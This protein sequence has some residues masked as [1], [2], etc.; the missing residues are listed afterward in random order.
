MA[1]TYIG[2]FNN[3]QI[4]YTNNS[5]LSQKVIIRIADLYDPSEDIV[6]ISLADNPVL[7]RLV[8]NSEDKFTPIR[9]KS[10]EI[11]LHTTPNINLLTFGTGGDNQFSVEVSIDNVENY[12]FKGW[13]SVSDIRQDF[14]PDPNVLVLTATDGLGF[15]KD[16]PLT[17]VNGN[18]FVG[19]HK[20]SEYIAACLAKTGTFDVPNFWV[21]EMNIKESTQVTNY[22]GH[23]YNTMYLD[24]KT[25]EKGIGEFEDCFTVLEKILGESCELSWNK[26]GWLIKNIDEFINVPSKRVQFDSTG[27]V[28]YEY[29]PFTFEKNIGSDMSQYSLGFMNDDAQVS[30]QRPYKTVIHEYRFEP[31]EEIP[32]NVNFERGDFLGT[33]PDETIDGV[34]YTAKKYRL[35]CWDLLKGSPPTFNTVPTGDLYIKKLFDEFEQES[36][37]YAVVKWPTSPPEALVVRSNGIEVEFGDSFDF[38]WDFAIEQNLSIGTGNLIVASILLEGN[39]GTYWFLDD[40]SGVAS[41]TLTFPADPNTTMKWAQSN[42][43][44]TV[45]YKL[46]T[47]NVDT[48]TIDNNQSRTVSVGK[49]DKIPVDGK[50][51]IIFHWGNNV[52]FASSTLHLS[53]LNFS[54]KPL[55]NGTY[56]QY[57]GT[58]NQV[59]QGGLSKAIRDQQ[60]YISDVSKPLFKGCLRKRVGDYLI[61]GGA[62]SPIQFFDGNSFQINGYYAWLFP[63]GLPLLIS[64][65]G[66]NNTNDVYVLSAEYALIPN[67]TVVTLSKDTVAETDNTYAIST[68]QFG[69]TE[70]FYNSLL[71]PSGPPS[72]AEVKPF[73][74]MRVQ[75]VFNQYNRVFTAFEGAIDGL[76]TNGDVPDL[77]HSY[78]IKDSHPATDYKTFKLLHMEQNLDLCEW[79]FYL[80]EV[81]D[82]TIPKVY[83]GHTFKYIQND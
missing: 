59:D 7:I 27:A 26:T 72:A 22:E 8:D 21:A 80:I 82:S 52:S 6:D 40:P 78:Y 23:F 57:S 43:N 4:D 74:Q 63:P 42:A 69:L 14:Q 34:T 81:Y 68:I 49:V 12:V 1:K 76:D 9:S 41:N 45:N 61:M 50:L 67:K 33:L 60:V 44:W 18:K 32:C 5:D 47:I 55:I 83:T 36:S 29:A 79:G 24:A 38:T 13:L 73:S 11:R 25:F 30:L 20:I 56:R 58:E 37:R 28:Q 70:G 62:I 39:N 2:E 66:L 15:L 53:N 10:C 65:T 31:P 77:I 71:Y 51:F 3:S 16:A 17:D 35:D 19:L 48:N 46:L 75:A 54:Y 64:G